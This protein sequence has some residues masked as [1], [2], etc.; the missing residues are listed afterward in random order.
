MEWISVN[1]K[2]PE[3]ENRFKG[4]KAITCNVIVKSVYPKG[5]PMIQRSRRYKAGKDY[6]GADIWKWGGKYYDRITHWIPDDDLKE[7]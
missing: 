7:V 5:K 2:L 6:N 4:R 3:Q 1:E